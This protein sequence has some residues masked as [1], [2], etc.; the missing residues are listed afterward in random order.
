MVLLESAGLLREPRMPGRLT[1]DRNR[2]Q[3]L[4]AM[5]LCRKG[6]VET[7]QIRKLIASPCMAVCED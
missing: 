4:F 7:G 5:S 6:I 3:F 2:I 1:V